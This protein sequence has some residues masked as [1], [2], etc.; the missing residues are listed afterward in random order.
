MAATVEVEPAAVVMV[1]VGMATVV[2][3]VATSAVAATGED[4]TAGV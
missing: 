2:T 1:A 4:G 3:G